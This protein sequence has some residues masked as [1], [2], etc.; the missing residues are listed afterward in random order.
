M[1]RKAKIIL[2][3][4]A[5]VLAVGV[6]AAVLYLTLWMPPTKQDFTDAKKDAEK[7][8]EYKG[9]TQVNDFIKVINK[10][11]YAGK[12]GQE[13]ADSAKKERDQAVNAANK[14]AELAE[15]LSKS[16]VLRDAEVKKLYD[17]YAPIEVTYG[18]FIRNYT[19]EYPKYMT[20]AASCSKTFKL[21]AANK[22]FAQIAETHAEY[23]KVCLKDLAVLEKSPITP[24]VAYAKEFKALVNERQKIFD[25]IVSK[26]LTL[27]NAI[28]KIEASNKKYDSIW[29][30][31]EMKEYRKKQV[32][33]GELQALTDLLDK[34]DN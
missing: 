7:I 21:G 15:K 34:K 6:I 12:T 25:D 29:V 23:R 11:Y 32:F 22:S 24:Y 18:A 3:S 30:Q 33:D 4:V 28:P 27:K 13:L 31:E 5:G 10:Q 8:I 16:R 2:I 26:D 17:V 19:T 1:S 9:L 14:R 20:S